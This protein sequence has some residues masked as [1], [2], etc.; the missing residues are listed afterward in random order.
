M[1]VETQVLDMHPNAVRNVLRSA[2]SDQSSHLIFRIEPSDFRFRP[3]KTIASSF[4]FNFLWSRHLRYQI[5]DTAH[6]YDIFCEGGPDI[7]SSAGWIFGF[8]MHELLTRGYPLSLFPTGRTRI[9]STK[10][11]V[12]NNYTNFH[13]ERNAEH[14]QLAE[15]EDV[16]AFTS[17]PRSSN[18]R[19]I[20]TCSLS[21]AT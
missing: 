1:M 11:D 3:Y 8:R 15:S 19:A 10:F 17:A 12:Y 4:A 5:S 20:L 14:F 6:F 16:R 18:N 2:E 9:T 13:H 7:A 21:E